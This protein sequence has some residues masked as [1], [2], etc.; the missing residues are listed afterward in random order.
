DATSIPDPHEIKISSL[1]SVFHSATATFYAPSDPSGIHG[2]RQEQM[3]C[4]PVWCGG[5]PHHDCV[6]V[7]VDNEQDGFCGMSVV[8]LCLLFSFQYGGVSYPC[9]LVEWFRKVGDEPD[10]QTGMWIIE[11]E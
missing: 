2:M 3:Q 11:P 7:V 9:A 1:I 10:G 5:A 4:T 6:Y 8:C